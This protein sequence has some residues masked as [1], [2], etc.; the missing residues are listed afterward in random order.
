MSFLKEKLKN[1]LS[2]RDLEKVPGSFDVIGDIALVEIRDLKGKD[3]LIAGA[4]LTNLN[5]VKVVAK[6]IGKHT[7][8]YRTQKLKIIGGEKRKE[9]LYKENKVLFRLDVEK[10]YFSERLSTE[11]LRIAKLI[12]PREKV[13]VLFSGVGAYPFVIAKNSRAKEIYGIEAN[14]VAHKYALE[15]LKLNKIENIKLL[16]GDVRRI[17]PRIREKFDRI[18]MPYPKEA[19]KFLDLALKKLKKNGTIHLY[20]FEREDNLAELRRRYS[21]MF[22]NIKLVKCGAYAP[23]VYRVCLDLKA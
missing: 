22:K 15:N 23:R 11:R 9:T 1:K 12:K 20:T 2:K 14:P 19:V 5:N 7:G 16:K 8:K 17:L 10:C 13:L 18:V 6:K 4:I 21:K 3:K